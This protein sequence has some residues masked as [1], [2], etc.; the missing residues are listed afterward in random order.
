MNR[1]G[2]QQ[3]GFAGTCR[4][5]ALSGPGHWMAPRLKVTPGLYFLAGR[6]LTTGRA[7]IGPIRPSIGADGA[8]VGADQTRAERRHRNVVAVAVDIKDGAVVALPAG[9]VEPPHAVLPHVAERHGWA[10]YRA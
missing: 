2:R 1:L 3:D 10:V 7:A 8:A 6:R 5:V 9:H 4:P